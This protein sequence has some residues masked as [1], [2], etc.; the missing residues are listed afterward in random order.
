MMQTSHRRPVRALLVAVFAAAALGSVSSCGSSQT[1][2]PSGLEPWEMN[3]ASLPAPANGNEFPEQLTFVNGH[4]GDGSSVT[5]VHARA[6]INA[7]IA[8]V[9]HAARDPQTGFDNTQSDGLTVIAYDTDANYQW[10]YRTHVT[11]HAFVVVDWFIEWRHGVV[12]GTEDAPRVY[13]V[14]WQK[15]DGNAGIEVMEGSLVLRQVDGH[16]EQTA[17]EYQYHLKAPF[18]N[19]T[20][21]HNYLTAVYGRLRDK[22]HGRTLDP[23]VCMDCATPP[24]RY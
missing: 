2:F 4:Y 16:P 17:V 10:S 1:S 9:A 12:E 8:D 7:P 19:A 6:Y 15:V 5:S 14:R 18:S 23:I 24:A 11:T 20:T 3:T 22:A 21:V 13:A